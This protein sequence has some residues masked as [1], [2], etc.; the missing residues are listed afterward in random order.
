MTA[1]NWTRCISL[2]TGCDNCAAWLCNVGP[3][4]RLIGPSLVMRPD[5]FAPRLCEQ[6]TRG[7]SA[8]R[9]THLFGATI[10]AL[11]TSAWS[12]TALA[13]PAPATAPAAP[14]AAP[15]PTVAPAPEAAPAPAPAA[16]D[17][18]APAAP[19]TDSSA[20]PAKTSKKHTM[21]HAVH[22]HGKLVATKAGDKAVDDLNSASLDSAKNGK[23][24]TAPATPDSAK[25]EAHAGDSNAAMK[26]HHMTHKA[27][28]KAAAPADSTAAPAADSTTPPADSSGK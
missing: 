5:R 16:P 18:S 6:P 20:P 21:H 9:K 2:A 17:T 13:Q 10:L 24:F 25:K 12:L 8:V 22:G 3:T 27:M 11:S 23:P 14:M 15:A 19:T 28:K 1:P 4:V 7:V 26:H